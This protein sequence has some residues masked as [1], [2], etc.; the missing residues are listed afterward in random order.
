MSGMWKPQGRPAKVKKPKIEGYSVSTR[1]GEMYM[2]PTDRKGRQVWSMA[3]HI[4]PAPATPLD[5]VESTVV[6]DEDPEEYSETPEV[7]ESEG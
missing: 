2:V 1:K 5:P 3:R 6:F 4:G 7:V